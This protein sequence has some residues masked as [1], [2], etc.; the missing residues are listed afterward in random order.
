MRQDRHYYRIGLLAV[1]LALAGC[2]TQPA[3]TPYAEKTVDGL[4]RVKTPRVDVAYVRPGADFSRYHK[5]M[6]KS[7]EVR[8]VKDWAKE[9]RGV[10]PADQ[11][12]IKQGLAKLFRKVFKDELQNKGG[13][14]VVDKPGP[15]VLAINAQLIDLDVNAPDTLPGGRVTTYVTSAGSVT[16]LGELTDSVSG[17]ILARVA[18][19]REAR[20]YVD[21]FEIANRVTNSMEARRVLRYWADLLRRHLNAV[22]SG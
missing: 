7:V 5:V 20:R 18:D 14:P 19:H 15:D 12:R 13:I 17:E 10:T 2:A 16:L 21:H 9:H 8:F 22:K 11:E 1:M 4:K 6:I 3:G